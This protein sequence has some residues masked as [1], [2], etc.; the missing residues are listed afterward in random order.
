MDLGDL[1]GWGEGLGAFRGVGEWWTRLDSFSSW[2]PAPTWVSSFG[3][4]WQGRDS[5]PARVTMV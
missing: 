2:S 4:W 3:K 5:G 1:Q